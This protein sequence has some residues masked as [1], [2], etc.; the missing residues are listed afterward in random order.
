MICNSNSWIRS[1]GEIE[2]EEEVGSQEEEEEKFCWVWRAKLTILVALRRMFLLADLL[3]AAEILRCDNGLQS[4]ILLTL[5]I[6][7]KLCTS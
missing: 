3:I 7:T 1:S 4:T 5:Y 6:I 2:E